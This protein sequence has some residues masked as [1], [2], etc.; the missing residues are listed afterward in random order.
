MLPFP[1]SA[2]TFS[3]NSPQK[4][5][6]EGGVSAVSIEGGTFRDN[7]ALE[8]GGAIV[9]WGGSTVVNIA[10]GEFINNTAK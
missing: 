6:C 9:A 7:S 2:S 5:Y 8:V 4:V 3:F 10:G 1:C